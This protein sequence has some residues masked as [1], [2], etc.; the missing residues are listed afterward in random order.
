MEILIVRASGLETSLYGYTLKNTT[1]FSV[2][3]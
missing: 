1:R 3:G 2:D